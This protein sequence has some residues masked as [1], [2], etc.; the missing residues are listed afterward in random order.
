[1]PEGTMGSGPGAPAAVSLRGLLEVGAWLVLAATLLTVFEQF[2][3][4]LEQF[5]HF[6]LQYLTA[7]LLCA[8]LF[9]LSRRFLLA[10]AMLVAAGVNAAYVVPWWLPVTPAPAAS[11]GET[12]KVLL[13]NLYVDNREVE[14]F[15][16]L[17]AQEAPDLVLVMEVTPLWGERLG[18]LQDQLPYRITVAREDP[19]GIGLLSRW[20]IVRQRVSRLAPDQPLSMQV[21]LDLN[22]RPVSLIASHPLPPESRAWWATRNRQLA[23][24]AQVARGVVGPLILLGD[25]NV[26][27]WSSQYDLL[28]QG[29]GLTNVRR[30]FGVLPTWPTGIPPAMIPLDHCLVTDAFQVDEVETGPPIGSDHLPLM[31]RLRLRNTEP[32]R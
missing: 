12:V 31:V 26:T 8:P 9:L 30:G 27:M 20:P 19:F 18:E 28:E 10:A 2:H 17:V 22:G 6:K 14:P 16:D 32:D 5:S 1:M 11:D 13:A 23:D 29:T 24:L 21:Q 25:L 15:L 3:W 7:A 4:L